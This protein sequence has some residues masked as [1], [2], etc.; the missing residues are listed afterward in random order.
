MSVACDSRLTSYFHSINDYLPKPIY[1]IN[2]RLYFILPSTPLCVISP[3]PWD[4]VLL[5]KANSSSARQEIPRIHKSPPPV[6]ILCQVNPLQAPHLI[7]W[8]SILISSSHLR[9]GFPSGLFPSDLP[10]KPC[11]CP[12]LLPHACDTHRLSRSFLFDHSNNV[13]W[14]EQIMKLFILQSP[15][16]PCNFIPVRPKYLPQYH[17]L[18]HPQPM[19]VS[20]ND[21]INCWDYK[22]W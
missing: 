20:F 7:S 4:G 14:G 3:T 1:S 10:T 17:I 9:L 6:L 2:Q 5:E 15:R 11:V 22:A 19:F 21:T 12:S 16:L 13:W 8:R 18:K